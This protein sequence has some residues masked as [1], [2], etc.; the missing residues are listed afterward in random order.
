MISLYYY[1]VLVNAVVTFAA[2]VAVFWRNRT[3]AVGPL[4]GFALFV[5][6]LWLLAFA[7]YLAPHSVPVALLWAQLTLSCAVAA[8]P[9]LLHAMCALV[10]EMRRHRWWILAS[11]ASATVFLVLLW[12]G[13]VIVG[14]MA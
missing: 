13:K 2:C 5:K 14:L 3:Q 12:E 11:Y 9:L 8:Q 6:G 4:L 7:Q 1:L 10:D